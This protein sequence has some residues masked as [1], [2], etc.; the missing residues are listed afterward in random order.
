[1]GPFTGAPT[2]PILLKHIDENSIVIR[3]I[4]YAG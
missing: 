1:M 2:P 3:T 4:S